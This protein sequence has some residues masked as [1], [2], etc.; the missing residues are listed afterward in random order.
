[1]VEAIFEGWCFLLSRHMNDNCSSRALKGNCLRKVEEA[2][3]LK[4]ERK[5]MAKP[6]LEYLTKT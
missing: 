6:G 2:S 1:M 5:N 3:L 4:N